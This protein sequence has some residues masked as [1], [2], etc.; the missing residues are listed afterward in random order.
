MRKGCVQMLKIF[1]TFLLLLFLSAVVLFQNCGKFESKNSSSNVPALAESS[2]MAPIAPFVNVSAVSA[3]GV[4]GF[5]DAIGLIVAGGSNLYILSSQWNNIESTPNQIDVVTGVHNPLT[6]LLANYPQI[7]GL[8]YN[9]RMIDSNVRTMPS[10]LQSLPF[11]APSVLSRFD[12]VIDAVA[13]DSATS[14]FT[15][16]LLG[17][18]VDGYLSQHPNEVTA[19]QTLLKRAIDRIHLKMP[20][21]KVGTI[22]TAN[23]AKQ[24]P[25]L[26]AAVNQ[27][28]DFIDYTYYPVADLTNGNVSSNWQMKPISQIAADLQFLAS[29]AGDKQFAFTEIGY[30]SSPDSGSS[31]A[32]QAEFVNEIFRVLKP[33]RS[34]G[35]VAFILYALLYDYSPDQC[36]PYAA[37]QN[38]PSTAICTFMNNLGLRRY[39]D[40]QPKP[41][42]SAFNDNLRN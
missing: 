6:M 2:Y 3:P 5:Q 24:Y 11:D 28:T 18:E 12:A 1:R 37:Q 31:E 10:D 14:R 21:V 17:N 29:N 36:A 19:F 42:W 35:K 30:S 4:Q 13:A 16:I 23:G 15:H 27:Y 38:V 32:Q 7:K 8:I 22:F 34:S 39:S 40:G 25:A 33:Y 9:L 20:G 26:F 41:A